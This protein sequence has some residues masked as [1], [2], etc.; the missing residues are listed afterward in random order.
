MKPTPSRLSDL[1]RCMT[2][3]QRAFYDSPI[4]QVRP[5]IARWSG[6]SYHYATVRAMREATK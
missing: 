5:I 4:P 6:K 1:L 2:P 3:A